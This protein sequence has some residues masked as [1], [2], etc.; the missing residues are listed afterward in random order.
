MTFLVPPEFV[1]D[2]ERLRMDKQSTR[3]VTSSGQW[4]TCTYPAGCFVTRYPELSGNYSS[5]DVCLFI[6]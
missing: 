2:I 6:F 3:C 4:E 1:W 5:K